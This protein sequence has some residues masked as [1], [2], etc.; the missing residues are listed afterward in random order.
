MAMKSY[1]TFQDWINDQSAKNRTTIKALRAFITKNAPQLEEKVKWGNGCYVGKN[2]GVIYLYADKEWVQYGFFNGVTL[3]DP[4]KKLEGKSQYIRHIKVRSPAD[5]DQAYF[6]DL[7]KQAVKGEAASP[8]L[9]TKNKPVFEGLSRPAL[10]ALA[11]AKI[12]TI[13]KLA[14]CTESDLLALHGFG[15]GSLPVVYKI[16]KTKN[17]TLK[18]EKLTAASTKTKKKFVSKVKKKVSAKKSPKQ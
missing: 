14:K 6:A 7:L 11:E 15:P 2:N 8:N 5:I 4:Q 9:P 12:T 13:A 16:L 10:G 18:S 17:L 1:D 3:S